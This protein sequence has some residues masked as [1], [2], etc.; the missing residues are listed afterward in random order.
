MKATNALFQI[1]YLFFF[2]DR[3][4]KS[5][6]CMYSNIPFSQHYPQSWNRKFGFHLLSSH[7]HEY[8]IAVVSKYI[9][10]KNLFV[11]SQ[12]NM[13]L[14]KVLQ[15]DEKES[16]FRTG[17]RLYK[18]GTSASHRWLLKLPS[19]NEAVH[20]TC[21]GKSGI[22]SRLW[23]IEKLYSENLFVLQYVH[24]DSLA[25]FRWDWCINQS[26]NQSISILLK[27]VIK[28]VK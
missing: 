22:K 18:E 8:T 3:N 24:F 16:G 25:D 6:H 2:K 9:L 17:S 11:R 27:D 10:K 28:T 5:F 7:A 15:G 26:I 20:I 1:F 4:I 21:L 23:L 12:Q 13:V 19:E 14:R